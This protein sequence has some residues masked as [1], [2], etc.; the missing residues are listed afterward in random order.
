MKLKVKYTSTKKFALN[1]E[2]STV[3]E[4]LAAVLAFITDTYGDD[5]GNIALSLNGRD[6]LP[7]GPNMTLAEAGVVPSDLLSV[8]HITSAAGATGAGGAGASAA[9]AG[10]A[11]AAGAS[12]AGASAGTSK[13]SSG[14]GGLPVAAAACSG[15]TSKPPEFSPSL[16]L[17]VK[18]DASGMAV[19]V[20][21]NL[22]HLLATCKPQSASQLINLL[23]HITMTECGFLPSTLGQS[24]AKPGPDPDMKKS[25]AIIPPVGWDAMVA[26]MQYTHKSFVGFEC[27]LVLVTMGD[28]KQILVSFPNQDIEIS[29]KVSIFDFV[30]QGATFSENVPMKI[31]ALRNV[32]K[33]A[34]KLRNDLLVPL[35]LAAHRI[36]GLPSPFHLAGLPF[37]ILLPILGLLDVNSVLRVSQTC[38]RLYDVCSD[39]ALWHHLYRRDLG[40]PPANRTEMQQWKKLY[41][42]RYIQKKSYNI[43]W[44]DPMLIDYPPPH[45]RIYP[46]GPLNPGYP[47]N[48]EPIG[49]YPVVPDPAQPFNPYR[50]PDSPF[51]GG[52]IPNQPPNPLRP[53]VPY[54]TNDPFGPM[55]D[56]FNPF[57]PGQD[58]LNPFGDPGLGGLGPGL[59]GRPRQPPR[60]GPGSGP[61][62]RYI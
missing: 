5:C 6:P 56:P 57:A 40:A 18:T 37:E 26:S 45:P 27:T 16:L 38:R 21:E 33:L 62:F 61:G 13:S 30:E 53:G 34:Q 22:T 8:I 28:L 59:P 29:T 3:D 51:Y 46:T 12:A 11:G 23:S 41:K 1:F 55:R 31:E 2:G 14:D 60:R 25:T 7:L 10:A 52:D 9:D 35:Q 58:P 39:D 19:A 32:P 47:Y 36:L 42:E 17:D 24:N 43:G 20:P 50:D 15:D 44:H 48:P 4:L 54:P 49:P